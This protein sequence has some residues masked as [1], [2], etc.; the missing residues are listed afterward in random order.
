[1]TLEIRPKQVGVN[2]RSYKNVKTDIDGWADVNL[3]LPLNFDL[4]YVKTDKRRGTTT[5]WY[6]GTIWDSAML[7]D[8]EKVIFWKQNLG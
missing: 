3:F 7:N 5:A 8:D 6:T 1:M 4:C 2:F